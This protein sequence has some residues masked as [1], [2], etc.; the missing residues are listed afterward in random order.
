M[1]AIFKILCLSLFLGL[2]SAGTANAQGCSLSSL[3]I[4]QAP[5]GAKVQSKPEFKLTIFNSCACTQT[6]VKLSCSGFQSVE[7]INPAVLSQSGGGSCLVNG[8]QPIYYGVTHGNFS[9]NYAAD[10]QYP[11]KPISSQLSC[12]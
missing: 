2:L 5:T 8:G 12:S 6:Q 1:A 11:F 7:K 9:F 4:L 3:I 10:N